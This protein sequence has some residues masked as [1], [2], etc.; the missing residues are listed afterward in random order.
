MS[1]IL[2]EEYKENRGIYGPSFSK[3]D[4]GQP[5]FRKGDL[6]T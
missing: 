4:V 3:M 1:E 2:G 5:I 6:D